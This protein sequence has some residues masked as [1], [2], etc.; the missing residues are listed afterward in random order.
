MSEVLH[1]QQAIK[2]EAFAEAM[3][4]MDNAKELLQKAKKSD[5]YYVDKKYVRISCGAAY[6]AVLI[7]LDAFLQLKGITLPKK[8]KRKSIEFYTQ[9]IAKLDGKLLDELGTVYSIIHLSGYYD[10]VRNVKILAEGFAVAYRI[11]ERIRP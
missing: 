8:G 1:Q 5:Y 9:H 6:H 7:A 10:G 3:R 11:I 2:Q 4:Y